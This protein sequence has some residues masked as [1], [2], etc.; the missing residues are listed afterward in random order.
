[1]DNE[2]NIKLNENDLLADAINVEKNFSKIPNV[3]SNSTINEIKNIK[4]T[5]LENTALQLGSILLEKFSSDEIK[6]FTS[7]ILE[8]VKLQETHNKDVNEKYQNLNE[9]K[10][11]I[12]KYTDT[13][14]L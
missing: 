11:D 7:K 13:S 3:L 9:E 8:G 2:Q 12:G 14:F 5:S 1:M 10:K 4:E 6:K